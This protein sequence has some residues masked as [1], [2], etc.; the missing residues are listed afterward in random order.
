MKTKPKAKSSDT[1]ETKLAHL[2]ADS[3]ALLG[4]TQFAHWNVQ[5]PAFFSLHTFLQTQYE[6]LFLAVDE[7]AERLR[8]LD[9]ISPGG[10]KTL[11][12]LSAITELDVKA[13]PAKDLVAHLLAAHEILVDTAK[14]LRDL[15]EKSG[16]AETQD[17][18]IKRIQIHEK[19]I[20]M[21]RSFLKTT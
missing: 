2:L 18:A 7:I 8:A 1:T 4:Q 6:E 14:A 10:L 13:H 15:A 17:L 11:A 12:S 19:T 20:W 3:Y 21:L 16:D 9:V 5:G